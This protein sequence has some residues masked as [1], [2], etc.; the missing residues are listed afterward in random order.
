M[1]PLGAPKTE[2]KEQ[3][4]RLAKDLKEAT[5]LF[6]RPESLAREVLGSDFVDHFG[7]TRL[8]EIKLWESIV[9]EWEVTRYMETV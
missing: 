5:D 8:H 6:M 1:A 2:Q 3:S 9:T 4:R 7:M